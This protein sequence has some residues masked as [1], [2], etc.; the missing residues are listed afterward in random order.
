MGRQIGVHK[1]ARHLPSPTNSL[2]AISTINSTRRKPLLHVANSFIDNKNEPLNAIGNNNVANFTYAMAH[3]AA[4]DTKMKYL[5]K[6]HSLTLVAD[7]KKQVVILHSLK[8]YGGTI[9]QPV[10]KVAALL[11]LGPDAHVVALDTTT[12]IAAQNKH[13]QSTAGI[14][15]TDIDTLRTLR[16][17]PTAVANQTTTALPCSS[18]HLSS[19]R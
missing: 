14:I 8:K 6:E 11:G 17:P 2:S 4:V 7:N 1:C 9:L 10:D 5:S 19:A 18:P 13:T 3:D 16:P 15:T 12:A